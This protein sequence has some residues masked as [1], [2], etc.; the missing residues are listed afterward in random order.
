MSL[1]RRYTKSQAKAKQHRWQRLCGGVLE[2]LL[3]GCPATK[4]Y[5]NIPLIR[6]GS[7]LL[8]RL[9]EGWAMCCWRNAMPPR[10]GF[11]GLGL[12]GK[13]MATR[14]LD[15]GYTVAVHNRSRG[16]VHEIGRASCRERV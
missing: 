6:S 10:L 11:I 4:A 2:F 15:A 13:P 12:M 8:P 14:L 5:S 1:A 7:P 3:P 9:R 16:A